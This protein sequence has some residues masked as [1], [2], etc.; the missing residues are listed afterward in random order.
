LTRLVHHEE[1]DFI[2]DVWSR[3]ARSVAQHEG[4]L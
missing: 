3:D 1:T 2:V 4:L